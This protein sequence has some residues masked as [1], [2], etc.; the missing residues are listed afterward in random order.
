MC[1][2]FRIIIVIPFVDCSNLKLS[3]VHGESVERFV[4]DRLDEYT[5]TKNLKNLQ[6]LYV[7]PQSEIDSTLL[8]DLQQLK[9]I[10]LVASDGV[11]KLF[12]QKKQ[13]Y[14]DHGN[15]K[16]YFCGFLLKGLEDPVIA[17]F[18]NDQLLCD[19]R[20]MSSLLPTARS[21]SSESKGWQFLTRLS[22]SLLLFQPRV[23]RSRPSRQ[24]RSANCLGHQLLRLALLCS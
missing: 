13:L 6:Y 21:P 8:F 12:A 5:P 10:H 2:L 1:W 20:A 18:L 11:S 3:L 19:T 23:W 16:I 4:T 14:I 22:T 17:S 15:L 9:E 7:G 24:R